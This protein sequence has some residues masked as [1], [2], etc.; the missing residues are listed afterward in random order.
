MK[1]P[2]V[3]IQEVHDNAE[4]QVQGGCQI[5]Y[6]GLSEGVERRVVR[7][8]LPVRFESFIETQFY[9]DE[10]LNSRCVQC[11]TVKCRTVPNIQVI[12]EGEVVKGKVREINRR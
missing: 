5:N 4:I 9:T 12:G 11:G 10:S 7:V 8:P 1:L 3:R 6:L 2:G